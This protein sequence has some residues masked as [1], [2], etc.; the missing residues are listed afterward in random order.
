MSTGV[1]VAICI[2]IGVVAAV[3][4][5]LLTSWGFLPKERSL[6]ELPATAETFLPANDIKSGDINGLRFHTER[7]GYNRQEVD[8]ALAQIAA[9]Y[10][11]REGIEVYPLSA[12]VSHLI[13][14]NRENGG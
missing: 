2:V 5:F 10:A 7:R 3:L 12:K 8:W 6:P 11:A 13:G 4:V 14:E 1:W 9:D